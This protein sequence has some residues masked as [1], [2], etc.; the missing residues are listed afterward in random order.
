ML[1][2]WSTTTNFLRQHTLVRNGATRVSWKPSRPSIGPTNRATLPAALHSLSRVHAPQ[3]ALPASTLS[4]NSPPPTTPD[5][6][7]SVISS[8]HLTAAQVSRSSATAIRVSIARG[9]PWDASHLWHSLRWS[10]S[11]YAPASQTGRSF[12]N[13]SKS[14]VPVD[15]GRAVPLVLPS[16]ALFHGYLRMGELKWAAKVA[17][18]MMEDGHELRPKSFEAFLRALHPHNTASDA[19]RG[20]FV[21]AN[22]PIS[23]ELPQYYNVLSIHHVMPEDPLT[24]LAVRLLLSARDHRWQRTRGMYDTVIQACLVQGEI[25]VASL[26]LFILIKDY[27]LRR[28]CA[29]LSSRTDAKEISQRNQDVDLH[30]PNRG[31][32]LLP[33]RLPFAVFSEIIKF[34]GKH[35]D[36]VNDPLF[37]SSSQGLANIA[38]SL[39]SGQL[40]FQSLGLLI[41]VLYSYPRS[42]TRVLVVQGD[43]KRF[44]HAYGYFHAVLHR[45]TSNLPSTYHNTRTEIVQ[46]PLDIEAYHSLLHYSLTQKHAPDLAQSILT[47]MTSV[48]NPPVQP[49]VVTYNILLRASRLLRRNDM[50]E[51]ILQTLRQNMPVTSVGASIP[52]VEHPDSSLPRDPSRNSPHLMINNTGFI[53]RLTGDSTL[54]V[55][56]IAHLTSTGRGG[57]VADVLFKIIPELSLVDHPEWDNV[58]PKHRAHYKR[59]AQSHSIARAARLGPHFFAAVINALGKVGK[60]GLAERV[61]YLAQSAEAKSWKTSSPWSLSIHAYTTMLQIYAREARKGLRYRYPKYRQPEATSDQIDREKKVNAV[62]WALYVLSKHERSRTPD[63]RRNVLG[64]TL[65]ARLYR[66]MR[67]GGRA[68]YNSLLLKQGDALPKSVHPPIPD[69]RFFN[70]ALS[71]F[72]RRTGIWAPRPLALRSRWRAR[73]R[74]A[75]KRYLREGFTSP[76]WSPA[77]EEIALDMQAAG[78]ALPIGVR[79][80]LLGRWGVMS[81]SDSEAVWPEDERVRRRPMSF[82]RVKR[83]TFRPYAVPVA[84]TKGLPL[85]RSR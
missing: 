5:S 64:R 60:T 76:H 22:Y 31:Y 21:R 49:D 84:K 25:L 67:L 9:N 58:L 82:G 24:R 41:K 71:L 38:S 70:A 66:S 80:M 51:Q 56:Y 40:P 1:C 33:R 73:L 79:E 62:G 52:T 81:T 23:P 78:F 59:I 65:G 19:G 12:R 30:A 10:H 43:D 6:K 74:R 17:Q 54:L 77:L 16:H 61:W 4:I 36:D 53:H 15:F 28:T 75:H 44:L 37:V 18:Q 11:H 85:S 47:H 57:A 32:Y 48:R 2:H 29:H 63:R 7:S 3:L 42:R 72:T 8:D 46:G 55:A 68:V 69:A 26:L 34:I 14:F 20:I 27:Q 83:P 35:T 50:S 45:L 13:P 39:D